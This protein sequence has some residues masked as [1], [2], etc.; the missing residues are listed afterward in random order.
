[1]SQSGPGRREVAYRLFAAEFD[2]SEL[3]YSE[4]DEERAPNYVVTPTGA[5]INRL[6]AVGVLTE[7]EDVNPEMVRGRV[8]DPTGAFVTYAGQYQPDALAFLE[9]ADPPLFLSLSGKARTYEPED[10][11]QIYTSV[12]PE[13]VSEVDADT[14]DR[15]IVTT[16]ERT[17]ERIGITAS[18]IESELSGERLQA[19]LT[20]AGVDERLAEGVTLAIDHYGTTPAYLD[21]LR[22]CAIGAVEVVAG[23]RDEAGRLEIAPGEGGGDA[24]ALSTL[25]LSETAPAPTPTAGD[26]T[27]GGDDGSEAL[28]EQKTEPDIETGEDTVKADSAGE[29]ESFETETPSDSVP[30]TETETA[31]AESVASETGSTTEPKTEPQTGTETETETEPQTEA[32]SEPASAESGASTV[33]ATSETEE[34]V[35]PDR[36]PEPVESEDSPDSAEMEAVE[37]ELD[38]FDP[39]EFELDED[40]RREVEEEFGTE[41][42]T[43]GEVE[44]ADIEAEASAETGGDTIADIDQETEAEA[45]TSR[46]A[47]AAEAE[48]DTQASGS[49][50][51]PAEPEAP[52]SAE[53]GEEIDLDDAVIETME[54][55]DDGD[56]ADQGTLV[57]TVSDEHGVAPDAV[58]EAIQDALMSG[59][60][61]EPTD[62]TL[63]SI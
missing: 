63:K 59:R 43:A 41:F 58:E 33:G 31:S 56:G 54:R 45:D 16:A 7:I 40:E 4:S 62:G 37:E 11:D 21:A 38:D 51:E 36:E 8:V 29:T 13:A 52:D 27:S 35:G 12:R 49:D 5:R 3:S 30:E 50:P 25:D 26:T 34:E 23:Q 42:S 6:F 53:A 39:G 22:E 32:E 60:C 24:S 48:P 19:S 14:R 20:E 18:A 44:S 1:M 15:W 10:G 46:A 17:I 9:R 2:D 47:A 57:E 55:L 28:T 61:Y